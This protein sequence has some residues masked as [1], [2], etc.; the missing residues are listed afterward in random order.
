MEAWP[1][2]AGK[3]ALDNALEL[4]VAGAGLRAFT[5][6]RKDSI[7]NRAALFSEFCKVLALAGFLAAGVPLAGHI[8]FAKDCCTTL[9]FGFSG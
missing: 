2:A 1:G 7:F 8:G 9:N 4:A 3:A 5:L 6:S